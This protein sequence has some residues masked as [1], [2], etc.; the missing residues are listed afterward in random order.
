MGPN[1]IIGVSDLSLDQWGKDGGALSPRAVDSLPVAAPLLPLA[2][3][4]AICGFLACH[5]D[6]QG[7]VSS[8]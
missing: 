3:L 4:K 1:T 7:Q 2:A 8:W 5:R 6:S